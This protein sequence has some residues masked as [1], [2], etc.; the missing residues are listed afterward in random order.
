M[1]HSWGGAHIVL[2]SDGLRTCACRLD[3][4]F[5]SGNIYFGAAIHISEPQCI[6]QSGNTYFR[7][8]INISDQHY[9]FQ[10][11]RFAHGENDKLELYEDEEFSTRPGRT[12][13]RPGIWPG[14]FHRLSF[15]SNGM[16][17]LDLAGAI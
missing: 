12:R 2:H 14:R 15:K 1:D 4:I 3:N 5:R 10:R 11:R 7:A 16:G 13:Y 8:A 9:I 6:F 17:P